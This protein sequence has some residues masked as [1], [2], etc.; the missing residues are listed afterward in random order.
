M[1]RNFTL[2]TLLFICL[3][4]QNAFAQNNI[5]SGTITDENGE[6]LPGVSILA[7]GS[8]VGTVTDVDGNYKLQI[9]S[10][11]KTLV[12]SFIGFET[13]ETPINGLSVINYKMKA[14]IQEL[15]HVVVTAF[16]ISKEEKALGYAVTEVNN[17]AIMASGQT[18][19]VT[20]LQGRVAGVTVRSSSG[21]PGAGA[22]ILIRGVT[23]LDPGRSNRPLYV[24]DGIEM[25]DDV[26]DIPILPSSGSNATTSSS[27]SSV[28]NRAV[29]IN[30][31]DIESMTILKGAQATALYGI[32]AANGAIIITTKKGK[33]G[34]PQID[35]YFSQGWAEVN[36]TP[37]VQRK[38]RDGIYS[39]TLPRSG[40]IWDSWG[41][42]ILPGEKNPS[43]NIYKDFFQTAST[44]EFGGSIA[45]ASDMFNYRISV[46]RLLQT[47]IIPNSDWNK[48]NFGFTSGIQVSPKLN[49]NFSFRYAN[50]GGNKPDEGDK[51]VLSALSYMPTVAD[52]RHYDNPYSFSN[53]EFAGIID[54]PMYL[55]QAN[56][57]KDNVNRYITGL[58]L[59]YTIDEH[60]SLNYKGGIDIFSDQRKRN[61]SPETDEGYQVN[62][63]VVD[64]R[65]N[66][67]KLTSNLF[68]QFNFDF[69]NGIGLSG[70]VGQYTY[71]T[72]YSYVST[73]GE[74]LVLD[75]FYNLD[76]T[77]NIYQSNS[78]THYRNAAVYGEITASYKHF[79][80]LS[81]T[82]RNDWSSTLPTK[83]DSYFFPSTSLSWVIS[84]MVTLP[85]AFTMVKLRGSYAVVGKDASPY[86]TGSYYETASNF[87]FGDVVGFTSSGNE[88]DPNLKPEFSKTTEV[89]AEIKFL[90]NRLGLDFTYYH[91]HLTDMILSVP[92]SY[93]SGISYYTTNAGAITNRGFEVAVNMTPVQMSSFTWDVNVNWY[94]NQGKVDHIKEGIDEI[95]LASNV[96]ITNKYVPGGKV[97]DLYGYN[98]EKNSKGQLIID[99]DGFPET[100]LTTLKLVGNAMQK[101][102]SGMTNT[103][104]YKGIELSVLLEWKKGGKVLDMGRRNSIRNGQLKETALRYQEVTFKGVKEVTDESGNVTGYT[105][106]TQSVEITPSFYRSSVYY[107]YASDVLLE[108]ASWFRIRNISLGY[109]LPKNWLAKSFIRS[110]K[111]SFIAYNVYLNTPVKGYDPETNYYGSGSGIYGYTGLKTPA[112]RSYTFKLNIGI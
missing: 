33:K 102:N 28:S 100:D 93:S 53:N 50:T 19:L 103:F 22:D 111:L 97:G 48:T 71:M 62:G 92:T 74:G 85:K 9:P 35:V 86:K 51:S 91:T 32:R 79:L 52:V 37:T 88:G 69:Q 63:F 8:A 73:R 67:F 16:G 99:S 65:S 89:G 104:S 54:N 21:A 94:T 78:E 90:K 15:D 105:P 83:N 87:P 57:Y 75:N 31:N 106:N 2:I 45:G 59:K 72:T 17:D 95:D 98:Y 38:Y 43:H 29:D 68:G 96:G 110:A 109:S 23:S 84:D 47:G 70:I 46:D 10:D 13:V 20:A 108:D 18:N 6:P 7:K 80:Y 55:T 76:N 39:T 56:R 24:I 58:N 66:N 25:S 41:S 11:V 60:F 101:W 4:G 81:I 42:E 36:K 3:F 77:T 26:N 1:K 44:Q 40:Y 34:T 5:V 14:D 61:V 49:A 12:F 112:T 107:N 82:G 64:A 30:P 27:Q